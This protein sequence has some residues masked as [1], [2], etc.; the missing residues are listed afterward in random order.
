ML[1]VDT[2]IPFTPKELEDGIPDFLLIKNRV[3][4]TE[5]QKTRLEEVNRTSKPRQEFDERAETQRAYHA[6]RAYDKALKAALD[7]P[8]GRIYHAA[9]K[10]K[11]DEIKAV[12]EA[13]KRVHA[14]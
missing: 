1:D 11:A 2:D 8:R 9:K 12:K 4:L 3:P 14:K 13:A 10:A 7:L 5:A 6:Q